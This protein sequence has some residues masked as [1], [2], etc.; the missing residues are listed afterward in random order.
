MPKMVFLVFRWEAECCNQEG[1]NIVVPSTLPSPFGNVGGRVGGQSRGAAG[2]SRRGGEGKRE[3]E[4]DG[5][6]GG[7]PS[8][9]KSRLGAE[10]ALASHR[11]PTDRDAPVEK[12]A[13]EEAEEEAEDI[14]KAGV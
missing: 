12:K 8:E 3:G 7:D 14:L 5:E 2:S 1:K 13:G 10:A 4:G 11:R 6:A 9:E